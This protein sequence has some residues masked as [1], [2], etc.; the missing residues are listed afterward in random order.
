[1]A[2]RTDLEQLVYTISANITTMQKQ[3]DRAV[4]DNDN[5]AK[6]IENRW[7]GGHAPKIDLGGA[8]TSIID[9]TRLKI[10]DSGIAR[11]GL[12][13]G[14]LEKLGPIGLIAAAGVGAFGLSLEQAHKAIEFADNIY[15]LAQ[16]AHVTTDELQAMAFAL[17]E[18]GGDGKLAAAGM[19]SFSVKLGEAQAGV[20]KA[21]KG[22]LELGFTKAQ[23]K[24]FD[25]AGVALIAVTAAIEKLK[26]P[27]QKDAVIE[28]LGLTQMKP[29]I[30]GGV[31]KMNEFLRAAEAAGVVMDASLVKKGHELNTELGKLHDKIDVQLKSA[32]IELGP[33]LLTLVGYLATMAQDAADIVDSFNKIENRRVQTLADQRQQALDQANDAVFG[34]EGRRKK[35]AEFTRALIA[36]EL[37][38]RDKPAAPTG[39]RSLIDQT[40]VP[41][42]PEDKTDELTK[43]ANED[44][45]HALK[46]LAEAYKN[47]TEDVQKRAKFETDA[48]NAE[49]AAEQAKLDADLKKLLK[50]K[51]IEGAASDVLQAKIEEAQAAVEAARVAKNQKVLRDAEFAQ[52]EKFFAAQQEIAG[53]LDQVLEAQAAQATTAK[54]RTAIERRILLADQALERK[55]KIA[56]L[57]RDVETGG[58]TQSLA[59]EQLK[60]FDEAQA[61]KRSQFDVAHEGPVKKYLQSIQ[62][63]NTVM[64][65]AS[66]AAAHDLA[67]GLADAIVNAK[68]LGDVAKNVFRQMAAQLLAAVI[69][70]DITGP[71]LALAGFADGT[72]FAPGGL[73]LVGER[74]PELVNLPRGSKVTPHIPT[75]AALRG[76]A[77]GPRTGSAGDVH[78][79]VSVYAAGAI[80]REEIEG[81]VRSGS[82]Q[83]VAAARQLA[84]SDNASAQ[85]AAN[86]NG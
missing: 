48:N 18:A 38:P 55:I 43:T 14:A 78:L 39:S 36:R 82:M 37:A 42:G 11:V 33:V 29:L 24:G 83:A 64:Q 56:T 60:S 84:R 73:A 45:Q 72:D 19:E 35:A 1:M 69:E 41:K 20:T 16:A 12:F 59:D 66:V 50:D 79:N 46:S 22:F 28:Q 9:N 21:Q 62:D 49:A 80:P 34:G 52:D 76:G 74:G 27:A 4:S 86:L 7:K 17:T 63:L 58:I 32:F 10:L 8:F 81:M 67:T 77:V 6:K 68:N 44:L 5:A 70:K 23:I 65:D 57:K 53:Y 40:K 54:E 30:E 3:L 85:Y 75:M 61:G 51:T 2:G 15:K 26:S 47:L 13:G 31:D 25:D 71:L